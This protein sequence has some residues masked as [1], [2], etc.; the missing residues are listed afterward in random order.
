M[1]VIPAGHMHP[2]SIHLQQHHDATIQ[3]ETLLTAQCFSCIYLCWLI[4]STHVMPVL[5]DE[6]ADPW[7]ATATVTT[8]DGQTLNYG[9]VC[10]ASATHLFL[11]LTWHSRRRQHHFH[12][13]ANP[14]LNRLL[15]ALM[16]IAATNAACTPRDSGLMKR[17]LLNVH[18]LSAFCLLQLAR[19]LKERAAAAGR[20]RMAA[21]E[22][23]LEEQGDAHGQM[24]EDWQGGAVQVQGATVND[25]IEKN[26][27]SISRMQLPC[28]SVLMTKESRGFN[29]SAMCDIC[30]LA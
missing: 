1:Q 8:T 10:L 4:A 27:R 24:P 3:Q 21:I 19:A 5:A 20:A 25:E 11:F 12:G 18:L 26:H 14:F 29:L 9:M 6:P 28:L 30:D 17:P 15:H 16:T 22:H 7:L 13:D 2:D 23:Q